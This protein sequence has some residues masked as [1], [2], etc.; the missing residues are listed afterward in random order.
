MLSWLKYFLFFALFS[1]VFIFISV[2]G[3]R[4]ETNVTATQEIEVAMQSAK[5][6]EARTE[7][8]SAFDKKAL[9]ANFI[10]NTV[11]THKD[12]GHDVKIDY[13]YLD[14]SGTVTEIESEIDSVQFKVEVVRPSNDEV[15]AISTQRIRLDQIP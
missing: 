9:V 3:V 6:G 4:Q 7:A 12:Q 13:V 2:A 11:Q 8:I 1:V 14:T 15:L 5:I 10:M